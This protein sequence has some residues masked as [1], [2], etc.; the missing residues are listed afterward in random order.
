MNEPKIIAI[1]VAANY[2][3]FLRQCVGNRNKLYDWFVGTVPG[4]HETISL[5]R[6]HDIDVTE[7]DVDFVPGE[8]FP[9][10]AIV[11]ALIP[12][13]PMDF[14]GWVLFM[15][16]DIELP[17]NFLF[18]VGHDIE[19]TQ[20]AKN[21]LFGSRRRQIVDV[22]NGHPFYWPLMVGQDGLL[23]H[24]S[25]PAAAH[26]F[27]QMMHISKLE[28]YPELNSCEGDDA[29]VVQRF[30]KAHRKILITEVLHRGPCHRHN[31]YGVTPGKSL[32]TWA[33]YGK[34]LES[35]RDREC[36]LLDLCYRS[37]QHLLPKA[38]RI[39]VDVQ[40]IREAHA[41]HVDPLVLGKPDIIIDTGSVGNYLTQQTFAKL[42]RFL[43]PNG[44][45]VIEDLR[46]PGPQ[47][48]LLPDNLNW[49]FDRLRAEAFEGHSSTDPWRPCDR[50]TTFAHDAVAFTKMPLES[51]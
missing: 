8:K 36:Q 4:D 43:P 47:H 41:N 26:G 31:W 48:P 28:P 16:A 3:H 32:D 37:R 45:Y 13:I 35:Y 17:P 19:R 42:W 20:D 7:V 9:R 22:H 25:T 39:D 11:N 27:F 12:K 24:S 2:S 34:L 38:K 18:L 29:Q 6:Q 33:I 49:V 44:I 30:D 14:D 1:T 40:A 21:C 46:T 5:C 23:T 50:W 10:G 51:P 15:D